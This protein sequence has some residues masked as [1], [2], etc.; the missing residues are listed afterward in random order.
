MKPMRTQAGPRAAGQAHSRPPKYPRTGA[1]MLAVLVCVG[2][3]GVMMLS[4]LRQAAIR[5]AE[6]DLAGRALQAR[7]LAEAALERAAARLG[8]DPG[9][10]GETWHLA[11]DSPAAFEGAIVE[12]RVQPPS[13]NDASRQVQVQADYPPDPVHRV[14]FTKETRLEIP[15]TT[16]SQR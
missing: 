4:I 13:G 9:Y 16:P 7:W 5:R 15:L 3:A 6:V 2:L 1:V 14:R 8:E 12:I 10:G 11:A